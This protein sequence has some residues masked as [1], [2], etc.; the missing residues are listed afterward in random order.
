MTKDSIDAWRTAWN[1][2][3]CEPSPFAVAVDEQGRKVFT[4]APSTLGEALQTAREYGDRP[5]LKWQSQSHTFASF[6]AAAD[7]LTAALQLDLNIQPGDRVAIGMR[8]RPEWMIAFM[9]VVQAGAIPVAVN[10]WST[11]QELLYVVQDAGVRV[12]FCDEPRYRDLVELAGKVELVTV[13]PVQEHAHVHQWQALLE[14]MPAAATLVQTQPENPALILYTSGT[15]SRPKGVVSS[16]RAVCQAIHALEFQGAFAAMT[17]AERIRPIMESGLQPTA[18]LAYPLFHVSGLLSQ[19]LSALRGGKRLVIL[20]KWD[21]HDALKMIREER[22]TQF[23]GVPTMMQ[24]L[25]FHERFVSDDTATLFALGLGGSSVS[26]A[27]L[28]KLLEAKPMAMTG[29]GYG[30]TEGNG[31]CAALSGEQFMAFPDSVGWPMP[32]VDV[33]I[34]EAPE[35]QVAAGDCGP[36]WIRTSAL[37]DG[38]WNNPEETRA[39]MREGWYFTGDVGYLDKHGMLYITDRI[40][41]IIIRGGENIS[42]VE[43]EHCA[44]EHPAVKEAAVFM[45][46]DSE[47]G[48]AVGM[49]AHCSVQVS[50]QELRAFMAQR[51]AAYK[52]PK[53]I[54]F[55]AH[56]LQRSVMG[57]LQK[58]M[59]KQAFVDV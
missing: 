45:L 9:A 41:D 22:I 6:F 49:V 21:I 31:I 58:P 52:L 5:F 18:L 42:A 30:M 17:S 1:Q 34:G 36:I 47:M 25:I 35:Q 7:S 12:A 55:S 37:M 48:E 3:I 29:N 43:V 40:K 50:E 8:N 14:H 57:K 44:A 39:S 2:L 16:Q 46:P 4:Q 13:D 38:Y 59:I 33:V 19:F 32:I 51:L 23:N 56:P 24:Q 10:S 53:R 11:R 20:Y 15:T 27:L 54:W 26:K 28:G